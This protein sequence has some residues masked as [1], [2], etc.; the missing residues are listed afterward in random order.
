MSKSEFE[1]IYVD[2]LLE[3]LE[4]PKRQ[5]FESHL[6]HCSECRGELTELRETVFS[7]PLSV[8]LSAP[9]TRLKDQIL[10][11]ATQERRPARASFGGYGWRAWAIAASVLLAVLGFFT[12]RIWQS[13]S[14]IKQQLSGLQEEN[15]RLRE[16][17]QGL[18]DRVDLLTHPDTRF[19]KMAGLEE[20]RGASGSAFLEPTQRTA[21]AFLHDLPPVTGQQDLQ[22]WVIQ[23]GRPP[24]PSQTFKP[25]GQ[26]TEISFSVPIDVS[27]VAVL[28]VTIE[29]VGGSPQPTG[30][31]VLA[32]RF[33][34]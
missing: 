22:M 29:P 6:A 16:S 12:W 3:Q 17:S 18:R 28:A 8:P 14:V 31:M 34:Q 5:E 21:V 10:A 4:N 27:Q 20:Y 15:R 25:A 2:Y 23:N 9:P 13:N 26:T 24:I 1:D 7:L 30:P 19:L 11:Q 32:G 33:E